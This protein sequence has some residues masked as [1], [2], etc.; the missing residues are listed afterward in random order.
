MVRTL[1]FGLDVGG[2]G[3]LATPEHI[4]GLAALGEA[5]DFDTLWVADHIIFPAQ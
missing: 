2:Y 4:L 5:S 1:N 3:A